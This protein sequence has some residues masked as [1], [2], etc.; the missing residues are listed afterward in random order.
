MDT[1]AT[2]DRTLSVGSG[3]HDWYTADF[4]RQYLV[5]R[6][7]AAAVCDLDMDPDDVLQDALAATLRAESNG[8]TVEDHASYVKRAIL[9]R[10]QSERRSL[11]R[12]VTRRRPDAAPDQVDQYPSDLSGLLELVAPRDR[13]LLY[14]TIVEGMTSSEAG[15]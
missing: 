15:Q 5:L 11:A 3:H 8:A 13:A 10:V 2:R 1:K 14:L 12:R 7:F 6:R 4:P 9:S